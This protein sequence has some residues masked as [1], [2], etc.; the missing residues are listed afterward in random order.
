MQPA[1]ADEFLQDLAKATVAIEKEQ[2]SGTVA[3]G[4]VRGGLVELHD[5]DRLLIVGDLHGDVCAMSSVIA[6]AE[7]EKLFTN[8]RNKL[9]FLGDYVDRGSD[10][11]GVLQRVCQLKHRHP[12]SVVLMRGNH[13]APSEFPFSSHDLP[14]A[15]KDQFGPEAKAA[16]GK[17]LSFFRMLTLAVVVRDSLLLVHGGLPTD[18]G[19]A[20][21]YR[22][23]VATVQ[24]GHVRNRVMEELLWN[25]PRTIEG[26]PGWEE[27]RRGIGRH[28][29][30]AV[31]E[32]WLAATG[33]KV[34]VRGHEPCRGYKIDHGGKVM[35]VFTSKEAYPGYA[36]ACI[37]VG[38]EQLVSVSSADDLVQY[39]V[40]L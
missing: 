7:S 32:R 23:L 4:T 17:V 27:S 2:K 34:V 29:G 26:Q 19:V 1:A 16:Y 36:A 33:A 13:E 14:Y 22:D 35:T 37:L 9:V 10:S 31:T 28:F 5:F 11:V 18:S 30:R 25:D 39:V 3:G 40:K 38:R 20:E 15:M 21:N 12:D 8:P 24:E 6:L